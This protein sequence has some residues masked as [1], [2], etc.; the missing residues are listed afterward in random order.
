MIRKTKVIATIG[1]AS[2]SEVQIKKLIKAGAN[3]FRI[4]LSHGNEAEYTS[5]IK[6]IQKV[7]DKL[8]LP[9]SILVDT[10][11][12]EIRVKTFANNS[13]SL[14]NKNTFVFTSKDIVGNENIVSITE[15]LAVLHCQIGK[16]ILANDGLVKLKIISKTETDIVCKV[17]KGGTLSN[18]KSLFF[19]KQYIPMQYLNNAD[20][21][22]IK[23]T[24]ELGVEYIAAS[25][26]S[27]KQDLIDLKNHT[28]KFDSNVKVIAKI[29]NAAGIKNIIEILNNCEGIMVARGD[30]GVELNFEELPVIQRKLIDI[31]TSC[32][33]L[34]IVATE[35]LESMIKNNRPTRAEIS[36]VAA[37]VMQNTSAVMLSG[38][39]A[40]GNNPILCVKTMIGI[41]KTAES[42]VNYKN[43]YETKV[44]KPKTCNDLIVQSALSASFYLN[45][46][47]IV[48]YTSEGTTA[49][50]LCSKQISVPVLAVTNNI[51]TYNRLALLKN[52]LPIL[53]TKTNSIFDI[54]K[55]VATKSKVAT[56]K[57]L[58]IVI[59]GTS[60][61]IDNVLKFVY[62]D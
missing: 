30:L 23:N 37:A 27:C 4:N 45:C 22:D 26:V 18:R 39:S 31:A 43:E 40:V 50:K 1:P 56:H 6:T 17:I 13:V 19:A 47:A 52:C 8:K 42:Y 59:T 51:K 33:K 2:C 55:T 36:D 16:Y 29:E 15:P 35:M 25:F 58:I 32:N 44:K 28:D 48:C 10:R 14:K 49:R 7:R 54:A 20:K 9:L 60:D 57:D 3:V 38:E 24:L 53:E 46:K 34:C 5:Y 21:T 61:K 12:P 11:G 41:I 62:I